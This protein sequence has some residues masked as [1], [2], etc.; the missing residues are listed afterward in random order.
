MLSDIPD[1]VTFSV[2]QYAQRLAGIETI[3]RRLTAELLTSPC[4]FVGTALDEPPLWQHIEMR[5]MRGGGRDQR[6][7]RPRSYLVT[8]TLSPAK[9]ALL[10]EFNVVWLPM[11]AVEFQDT[12]LGSLGTSVKE[13]LSHIASEAGFTLKPKTVPDVAKLAVFPHQGSDYLLG[14]QPIWADVQSGRAVERDNDEEFWKLVEMKLKPHGVKGAIIVSGTAGSGKSTAL[15]KLALRLV[16]QGNSVSWVSPEGDLS[17]RDIRTSVTG[18]KEPHVIA[19]DDA[20]IYGSEL[21]PM[22]RELARAEPFPLILLAIRSGRVD[23]VINTALLADVALEERSI[24]MLA[25]SDIDRLLDVLDRENRLG[26][27]KGQTRDQQRFMFREQSGKRTARR[28]DSGNI[29]QK[30]RR[31]GG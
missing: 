27:L 21:T 22:V 4:V 7:F 11:S 17:P 2:T 13:G 19:I 30:V 20:D 18:L 26:V 3:Y 14:Q 16:A 15:M 9:Q 12:V 23:R 28:H 5:R 10:A 25:D 24:P 1:R 31:Q 6:E 8:Q 29:G